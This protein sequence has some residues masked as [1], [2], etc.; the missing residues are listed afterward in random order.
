[1][2][3]SQTSL[4]PSFRKIL[5]AAVCSVD[6]PGRM[7]PATKST[8]N[9]F[10]KI[11]SISAISHGLRTRQLLSKKQRDFPEPVPVVTAKLRR[12]VAFATACI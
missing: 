3:N 10:S 6:H 2:V 8:I 11:D 12:A 9:D 7:I 4:I 1:M 5:S